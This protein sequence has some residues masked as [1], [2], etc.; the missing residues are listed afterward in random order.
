MGDGSSGGFK[1]WV[2]VG[3]FGLAACSPAVGQIYDACSGS[4]QCPGTTLCLVANTTTSGYVGSFCTVTCA[5]DQ[6]CPLDGYAQPVC[7]A[8][9]CYAGCP[10]GTGCPY[11][12]Q[13]ATDG[14]VLFCVP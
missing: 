4:E 2:I 8:G 14:A 6:D 3:T 10:S 1:R 7:E 13:C 9:Q 12:E 5:A 11:S